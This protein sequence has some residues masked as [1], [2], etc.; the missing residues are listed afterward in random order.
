[1]IFHDGHY[2]MFCLGIAVSFLPYC[3][4]CRF[5]TESRGIASISARGVQGPICRQKGVTTINGM[6]T[7]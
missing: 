2:E 6:A 3:Q 7:Q 1:M 5:S 4:L